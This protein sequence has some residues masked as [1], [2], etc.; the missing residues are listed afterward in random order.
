MSFKNLFRI[1]LKVIGI[2]FIKDILGMFPQ[3]FSAAYFFNADLISESGSLIVYT[4]VPFCAFVVYCVMAYYLV[5]KSDWVINK[6]G[7]LNELEGEEIKLNIHRSTIVSICLLLI[8]IYVIVDSI[9]DF[10][11]Y[12]LVYLRDNELAYGSLDYNVSYQPAL[13]AASK[14]LIAY[15]VITNQ[16]RITSWIEK[17]SKR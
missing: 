17:K 14:I 6:L 9:P 4:L 7:L 1:I 8:G 12:S 10:V 11:S 15:I 16:R 13:V 2:F 3:L 5:A